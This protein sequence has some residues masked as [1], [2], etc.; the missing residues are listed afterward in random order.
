MHCVCDGCSSIGTASSHI[1]SKSML[2]AV[3]YYPQIKDA[4]AAC[5][6]LHIYPDP[7]QTGLRA[8][9]AEYTGFTPEHIVAGC[10]SDEL[11]DV[12]LRLCE[13]GGVVTCPPTFGMY[14]FLGKICRCAYMRVHAV[15]W[16]TVAVH[17][18]LCVRVRPCGVCTFTFS[19]VRMCKGIFHQHIDGVCI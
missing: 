8:A 9:L 16:Y 5:N 3:R 19:S 4:I 17:V 11:L 15:P 18:Y 14:S 13:P 6:Q 7:A 1:Q 2:C 10:G 12:V